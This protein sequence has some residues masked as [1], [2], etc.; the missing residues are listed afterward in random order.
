MHTAFIDQ[1]K[2]EDGMF[3]LIRSEGI[4]SNFLMASANL[5]SIHTSLRLS[6]FKSMCAVSLP[7]AAIVFLS[8][9]IF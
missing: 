3:G 4:I 7:I 9:C 6:W 2:I 5:L 8:E 1:I